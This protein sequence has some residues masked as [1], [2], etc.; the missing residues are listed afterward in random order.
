MW[1]LDPE[2]LGSDVEAPLMTWEAAGQPF[3]F[4]CALVP[5]HAERR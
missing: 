1:A 5:S 3:P 4:L 2:R